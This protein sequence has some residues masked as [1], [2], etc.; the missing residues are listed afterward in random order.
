MYTS[1]EDFAKVRTD[2][3][4]KG[5]E[6]RELAALLVEKF[7]EGMCACGHDVVQQADR[8]C[9]Q[10]DPNYKANRHLRYERIAKLDLSTPRSSAR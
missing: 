9:E 5:L 7:A 4:A 1:L 10:L 3:V 8:F 6:S 2:A